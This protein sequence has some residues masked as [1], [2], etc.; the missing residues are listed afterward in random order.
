M[1]LCKRVYASSNLASASIDFR[2]VYCQTGRMTNTH[3]FNPE[4]RQWEEVE[5][6]PFRGWKAR[7]E[8][9]FRRRGLPRIANFFAAWDE[10]GL[11]R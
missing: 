7:T 11:G 2:A 3:G 8:Q 10:R 4:T 6:L 5:P 1:T 9:W